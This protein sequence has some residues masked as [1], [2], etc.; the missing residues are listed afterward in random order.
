LV[1][2]LFLFQPAYGNNVAIQFLIYRYMRNAMTSTE[3]SENI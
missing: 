2:F 3:R 1:I